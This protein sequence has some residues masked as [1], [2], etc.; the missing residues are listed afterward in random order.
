VAAA[1][2]GHVATF[3]G[4]FSTRFASA[5]PRVRA[6][7]LMLGATATVS[8]GLL[9]AATPAAAIVKTVASHEYGVE[10]QA[11][12]ATP[13]TPLVYHSG[14]VVHSNASYAIYWDPED[15]GAAWQ[16]LT[17][18]FLEGAADESGPNTLT[19]VNA[20]ATQYRETS[21]A[22]AAYSS[23]FRGAYT[24]V[25]PFTGAENCA[26]G[27]GAGP[28]PTFC[29]SD[30]QI[31]T[32]LEKYISANKLP[33]GLNPVI[34]GPTP[35][36][37]VFTPPNVTV[38]LGNRG[39][40][41]HCS[42]AGSPEEPFCSYHSFTA[43]SAATVL[44]AVIPATATTECQD[45]KTVL[46]EP[47]ETPADII[48]NSV[49]AEQIA[50]VTNPKLNGWYGP[51]GEEVPDKCR[52]NFLPLQP[53]AGPA[54]A[55][56]EFNQM[57]FGVKYYLNDE[58]NQAALYAPYPGN[59]CINTVTMVP[60]FTGPTTVSTHEPVTF[61]ST[62][63]YIDLGIASY[64]WE[65]G[66][67]ETA[68]VNCGERTPTNGSKP[69]QCNANS[70][71]GNPNPVASVVHTYAKSGTYEVKLRVIDDGG[72]SAVVTHS[73]TVV[74]TQQE[75]E[76]ARANAKREAE[77]KAKRTAEENANH[78]TGEKAKSPA[79]EA[80]KKAAEG[81]LVGPVAT[82]GVQSRSLKAVLASGLVVRYS[83]NEQVAGHFEVLLAASVAR[84]IGLH[85]PP[86]TGLAQG[87]PP[88]IV[89]A[90]AILV[91]TKGGHSTLRIQLAKTTVKRLRRLG[92]VSLMLRL[93]LRNGAAKNS[94]ST[95][96][97]S[98]VTLTH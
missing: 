91:T 98:L 33:V 2:D 22:N 8:A 36:Y 77:D 50:A 51:I 66:P 95:T 29:V 1:D 54:A 40:T 46:E 17:A 93:V 3:P 67:G 4:S 13:A 97:L 30:E 44:Y 6:L 89:I 69:W 32:E 55:P 27:V 47:N 78:L 84:R 45:N 88:Q 94:L 15:K 65:F 31:R 75:E 56:K 82:A 92:K 76:E 21:G 26:V 96:V 81:K 38:C 41:T 53:V 10:P 61:N 57:I 63:S 5:R 34:G 49:A 87:T 80:A 64:H 20:V 72:H 35:I 74:P 52:Y 24:D 73:I 12:V 42:K 25:D 16:Q 11:G 19:N 48:I 68:E 85:G 71:T 43:V 23:S 62:E 86:A 39:G 37:F 7:A 83:V 70:G 90:K 28:P 79:E 59:A 60:Q 18:G 9:L 14:E 58:F